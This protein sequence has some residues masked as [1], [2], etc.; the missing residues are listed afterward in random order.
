M[1]QREKE[2]EKENDMEDVECDE[3]DKWYQGEEEE[4]G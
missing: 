3:G 4:D 1:R 2:K